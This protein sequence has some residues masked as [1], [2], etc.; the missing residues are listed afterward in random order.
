LVD[1]DFEQQMAESVAHEA[2]GITQ[3]VNTIGLSGNR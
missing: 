3:V 2:H 1:I